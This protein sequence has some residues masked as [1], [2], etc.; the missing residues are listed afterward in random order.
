VI[1]WIAMLLVVLIV[2]AT[3]VILGMSTNPGLVIQNFY[4]R[5]QDYE[6]NWVSRQNRD[7]GW[8]L[9]ADVPQDL[10]AGEPASIRFFLVD[11]AGQPAVVESGA[12]FHAYR[13]SDVKQDF[14]LPMVAE[15]RGRFR[16]D[17]TFP[18]VGVWDTL[19]A[20]RQGDEEFS[21][22]KRIKVPGPLAEDRL[23]AMN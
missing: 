4:D 8:I 18:L 1:G 20:V 2:N 10:R 16:V 13:P 19:V 23:P 9:R 11:R 15:G 17:V 12:H 3:L 22:G 7:P 14:D 6:K 21:L 5:G